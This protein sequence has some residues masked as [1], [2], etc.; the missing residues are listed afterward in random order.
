VSTSPNF[1]G[2]SDLQLRNE[3]ETL[4]IELAHETRERAINSIQAQISAIDHE[5]QQRT[6][7]PAATEIS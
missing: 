5:L 6:L 3:L 2:L 1:D 4:L 7:Q